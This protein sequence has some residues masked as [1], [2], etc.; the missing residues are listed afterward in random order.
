MP[1]LI[2]LY[3]D[4]AEQR[5]KFE[6]FAIHDPSVK[7]FAELDKKLAGIK[8]QYWQGKDLPF[9]ILLD[10]AG[11][12]AKLYGID[13]WPT[14]LLIDPSGKLVGEAGVADLEAKLPRLPA[15]KTWARRRDLEM[16]VFWSFEPGDTTLAKFAD[17][18]KRWS[19]CD[20]EVDA[21]AVRAC[22]LALDGPL[23]GVVIG[24][25][26]TLRSLEQLL[27]APH[28]L[29]VVPSGD[30]TKL[31]ITRWSGTN[32]VKSYLQKLHGKELR[33]RLERPTQATASSEAKP[34]EIE[35]QPLLAAIKLVGRAFNLPVGLEAKAMHAG[36]IDPT[37]KVSGRI[38]PDDLRG[39]LTRMLS[40][41][42]LTIAVRDE[43][44][45]VTP[46][47]K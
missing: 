31:F 16:N 23:P 42:G 41:L 29:G 6:V 25:Q 43:V 10:A 17:I 22:G 40:P 32:E 37:A 46:K 1:E 35:N 36:T 28:G 34:L 2:A 33:E 15:S 8:R 26:L 3:E 5:D 18:L 30:G 20:V 14:G 27:L 39:S 11:A 4:H 24:A 19:R 45:L 7:S 44:I 21:D 38:V 47:G 13:H 12:T 9:P